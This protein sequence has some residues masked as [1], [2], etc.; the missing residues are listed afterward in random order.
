MGWHQKELADR[1]ELSVGTIKQI[2]SGAVDPRTS[3]MAKIERVF[4]EAGLVFLDPG[5]PSSGGGEGFR[6]I[7]E[8]GPG[9]G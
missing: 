8:A 7:D 1:A 2:E 4:R 3:T 6:L 9:R 5:E